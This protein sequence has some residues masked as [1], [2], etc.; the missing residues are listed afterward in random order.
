LYNSDYELAK[1][2]F[3]PI[4]QEVCGYVGQHI[5]P[6]VVIYNEMEKRKDVIYKNKILIV[7]YKIKNEDLEQNTEIYEHNINKFKTYV[8]KIIEARRENSSELEH[9]E[10]DIKTKRSVEYTS[11][12]K[13][14]IE[15]LNDK[16][17]D[18]EKIIIEILRRIKENTDL[19]NVYQSQIHEEEKKGAIL[20]G[21][22]I[23]YSLSSLYSFTVYEL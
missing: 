12:N 16:I 14:I 22:D 20:S 2:E 7:K 13:D 4:I 10:M 5:A 1:Q 23:Y 15:H 19:I 21:F 11:K 17:E 8:Q 18:N 9:I 3:I 6:L